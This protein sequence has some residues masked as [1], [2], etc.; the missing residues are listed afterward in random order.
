MPWEWV[1]RYMG[2][3]HHDAMCSWSQQMTYEC[4]RPVKQIVFIYLKMKKKT[5]YRRQM[6]ERTQLWVPWLDRQ[7]TRHRVAQC[8]GYIFTVKTHMHQTHDAV[9]DRCHFFPPQISFITILQII[10]KYFILWLL[11]RR[12]VCCDRMSKSIH[13]YINLVCF[14]S[15]VVVVC[16]IFRKN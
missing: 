5:N 16:G 10:C 13:T 6:V 14:D 8:N 4:M 3:G 1:V 9:G 2:I 7:V 15:G 12:N 11:V